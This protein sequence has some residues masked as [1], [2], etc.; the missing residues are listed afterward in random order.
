M[1]TRL[2]R[3]KKVIDFFVNQRKMYEYIS[4]T[5]VSNHFVE[6]LMQAESLHINKNLSC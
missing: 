3:N 2:D 5:R 6:S 4:K 1:K